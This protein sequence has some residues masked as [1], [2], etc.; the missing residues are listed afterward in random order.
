MFSYP[1]FAETEQDLD[2]WF[3]Y[4]DGYFLDGEDGTFSDPTNYNE[5][6]ATMSMSM[7]MAGFYSNIGNDGKQGDRQYLHKQKNIYK[8]LADIG[9]PTKDI[10]ISESNFK[11]PETDSIGVAIGSKYI[12]N[13][14]EI[15]IP[16]SVRGAGYEAEWYGNTSIGTEGEH[17]GFS[18]AAE[19]VF[20][21]VQDYISD[22]K[23]DEAVKSGKVKFWIAGYSR[24]GATSN[25]AAKRLVEEYCNGKD[26]EHMNHVY[27]YCFEAPK[28]GLNTEMLLSPDMYECIHNCI[29]NADLVPLVAP[30]EMGFIRYGVDHYIPGST[31]TDTVK[32]ST[33]VWSFVKNQEFA[34]TYETWSDNAVWSVGSKEYNAQRAKMLSQLKSVDPTGIYFYDRFDTATVNYF[35]ST[36]GGDMIK[37]KSSSLKQEQFIRLFVRA[38]QAWGLYGCYDGNFRSGITSYSWKDGGGKFQEALQ[39]AT[40]ILFGKTQKELDGIMNAAGG[41]M[42][43]IGHAKDISKRLI[44]DDLVG[45]WCSLT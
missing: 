8:L 41:I 39:L 24:A 25:L 20:N 19:K 5:H 34:K 27:A 40:K 10:Y 4:T 35:L 16:I 42:E 12:G 6:L 18:L 29:N 21:Q 38:F 31:D 22:H 1:S 23:L 17:E 37:E 43:R 36:F 3:F 13:D 28:G 2:A 30:E 44:W 7:A 9:V 45:D 15:L 33:K 26:A 32:S 14:G 11:K